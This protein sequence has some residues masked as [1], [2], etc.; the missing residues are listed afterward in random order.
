M[1]SENI[2]YGV[3]RVYYGAFG[4]ITP[5]PICLKAVSDYLGDELDY[6]YAIVACG[7]AFRF[8]WDTSS[9]NAGNVDIAHTYSD[10]EVPFRNGIT[11]LGRE[12]SMLWRKGCEWHPGSGEKEDFKRFIKTQIDNGKPVISLGPIGPA[13]AGIIIGYRNDGNTLLGWSLFQSDTDAFH[14]EGYYITDTW[15]D[16]GDFFGVMALGDIGDIG[17]VDAL[18]WGVQE[19]LPHAIAA[20]EGRSEDSYAKGI[21]AYDAWK[22]AILE[23]DEHD[24]A[25]TCGGQHLVMMCQGDATDCLM[26]GRKHACIYFNRLAEAR[27]EQP[28]YA[29]I[30]AQ[31][32]AVATI[33]HEKI[34]SVLGGWE[35][36]AEQIQSLEEIAVRRQIAV[37]IDEMKSADERALALM[38]QLKA[39]CDV[40]S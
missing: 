32:G 34:Y 35:R 39:A 30:A 37:Y 9:W 21:A 36:G 15:W 38:K 16:E 4:G 31:F 8:S 19:I 28:L 2:L 18:R 7:G 20:L 22:Q 24:F 25:M 10:A 5:F 23:A 27:P 40:H 11:A 26:D 29:D 3:P 1:G 14:D 33:I 12:F 6:S 13:E 17:D